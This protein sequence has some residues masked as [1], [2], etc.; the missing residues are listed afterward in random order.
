MIADL[1]PYDEYQDSGSQWLKRAPKHW[2]VRSLRSLTQVRSERNRPELTLLS[3]ERERGV[4]VRDLD[5]TSNHNFIPDDLSN[6]KVAKQGDLVI[7][8]MKAWQGSMGIAPCDGIVSPAYYVY[9]FKIADRQFAHRLLRSKPYVAHFCQASDGVRVGQW[10]LS[11][12]GMREIPVLLPPSDEQALIVRFLDWASIRL[13]KAIAAK[14][15]VIRLFEEQKQAIIHRAVTRGL[16]ENVPL[17]HSGLDWLGDVP[18]HWNVKRIK[19]LMRVV[20]NRSESGD[21]VLLS[22]RKYH[23]LVPYHEHFSKPPQAAT[24]RGFKIIETGQIATNRMQAGFGLI[25]ESTQ[26]GIVSPDFGVFQPTGEVI[27]EFLG[28]LFRSRI[29]SAKFHSESKGLGTGKSGFMRLYDDRIGWIH[30]TYPPTIEEQELILKK[31]SDDLSEIAKPRGMVERE[32]ELLRE[33]QTRLISDVVTG[34]LDVREF[35]RSLPD[36]VSEEAAELAAAESVDEDFAADEELIEEA[37]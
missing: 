8:K 24:L 22:M 18:E 28:L 3:V 13:G 2:T 11:I 16:D 27:P 35:A 12:P 34:K 32:I 10:D 17:K 36:D 14:R 21:E 29:V 20:D 4:I 23:G 25:F 26:R 7:N 37:V 9:R 31:L 30:I 33:Y 1:K 19:Y 6:Y 15:K 5:S